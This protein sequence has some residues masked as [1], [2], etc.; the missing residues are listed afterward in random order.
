MKR[1]FRFSVHAGRSPGTNRLHYFSF[2]VPSLYRK[3]NGIT[4]CFLL[5]KRSNPGAAVRPS[6][7]LAPRMSWPLDC[8]VARAPRNDGWVAADPIASVVI[9]RRLTNREPS[10]VRSR[11]ATEHFARSR[12]G[13]AI[14]E[15]DFAPKRQRRFCC[16]YFFLKNTIC[17]GVRGCRFNDPGP[18]GRARLSPRTP[19]GAEKLAD[20]RVGFGSMASAGYK[21]AKTVCGLMWRW[22]RRKIGNLGKGWERA[23][24]SP[25]GAGEVARK[26]RRNGLKRLNPRP[27]MVWA[28]KPRTHNIWYGG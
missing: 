6:G 8:F 9:G 18:P 27:E 15:R 1:A 24:P 25:E 17:A 16:R 26:W 10:F 2:P 23:E 28:R 22:S 19:Q 13:R 20:P 7:L 11:S 12:G 14:P 5:A 3:I 21:T 4:V